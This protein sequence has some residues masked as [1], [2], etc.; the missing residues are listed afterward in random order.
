MQTILKSL[1]LLVSVGIAGVPSYAQEDEPPPQPVIEIPTDQFNRGTPLRSVEGFLAAA[2]K[3]DF[4]RASEYLDMRNL[5]GPASE[6]TGAQLARRLDVIVN[7][8]NWI[9][10]NDL[11]DDPDGRSAD[12]LPAYR[13][14]IGILRHEGN[15]VQLLMQKVPRGDGISIWKISNATVVRIPVLYETYG[16]PEIVENLRRSLPPITFAGIAL[17]KMVIILAA[18]ALAYVLVFVL[19]LLIRRLMG[20]PESPSHR[21]I[22]R[23]LAVPG[24]IW[25][26]ALV[27][28]ATTTALGRSVT[29]ETLERVSPVPIL[30]TVWV[31][32]AGL[33]LVRDIYANRLHDRGHSAGVV[34]LR[35][36]SNALKLLIL[37]GAALL[38]LDNLGVN[39]TTVLA[40]LG[41]GGI[42]VALALQKPM[43]DV[44]GAITLYTQQPIRVG[45][46][47]RIGSAT[48]TI[49]EIG[50]RT[51][52]VRTLANTL[53]AVPNAKLANEAI[54]NISAREKIRYRPILRLRYDTNTEQL[55]KVLEGIRHMLATHER[56]INDDH[57][58][59]FIEFGEDALKI[60]VLAYVNTT[61]WAEYLEIAE[62][63]NIRIM[64]I[65]I[66]AGT[67]L[68][69]PSQTLL[70]EQAAGDQS[71]SSETS[72]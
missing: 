53:I 69:L 47:C 54:D 29:A 36:V 16:Y 3:G 44:F 56:V 11:V 72:R 6:L 34:L 15:E 39:I 8:A 7:R 45:D 60:E 24:G 4:E 31:M 37:A 67:S 28:N 35:P 55:Q 12:G 46:F 48:G 51:T 10:I 62:E 19:A 58:V 33:N 9:E 66:A 14:P 23:F 43:E 41:V 63:L 27:M 65:V 64:K 61:E 1:I 59:R 25:A 71:V 49:E 38:Y 52:R 21:R 68:A 2:A 32:F 42:A 50:L 26:V 30:V 70:V 22:F 40:G 13:D 17:Y 57:R 20:D 18:G 5:H